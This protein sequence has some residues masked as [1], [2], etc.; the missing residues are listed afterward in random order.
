MLSEE[1]AAKKEQDDTFLAFA[2]VFSGTISKGKKLLVL[3]PKH[4][5]HNALEGVSKLIP[6]QECMLCYSASTRKLAF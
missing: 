1:K 2:R 3:G 6:L 4:D 5:P